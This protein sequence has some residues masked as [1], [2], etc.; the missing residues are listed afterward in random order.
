MN[1][2]KTSIILAL[3]TAF[4]LGIWSWKRTTPPQVASRVVTPTPTLPLSSSLQSI[5]L[6]Q[7][8]ADDI[9]LV[10]NILDR[11]VV[12]TEK[13]S[14]SGKTSPYADVFIND[15]QVAA[16]STGEFKTDVTLD[17]G[18][19][20]L[21]IT[22]TDNSGNMSEKQIVV[23]YQESTNAH[24]TL[25]PK[26]SIVGAVLT[27]IEGKT[28]AVEKDG[29]QYTVFVGDFDA[30]TTR[31]KRR[32]WGTTNVT[33]LA[34]GDLLNII[35]SWRDEKK[36]TL[37]ACFLRDVSIQKVFVVFMGEVTHLK[38]N[39]WVVHA[40][41]RGDETVSLSGGTKLIDRNSESIKRKMIEV[42]HT[43][44]VRGLWNRATETVSEVREVKDY[45][46]PSNVLQ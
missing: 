4:V 32:F 13:T 14:I 22:A 10:M 6:D 35:G 26:V 18:E 1:R 43:V 15:S 8:V 29:K 19:N 21:F 25:P 39:G 37:E 41:I 24:S 40:Q 38:E 27:A 11:T 46:I 31:L 28:L 5:E 2:K 16:D 12:S 44:R 34:V 7:K 23:S 45:S 3:I 33:E 30:C 20:Y 36:N 17:E 9:P 42:G